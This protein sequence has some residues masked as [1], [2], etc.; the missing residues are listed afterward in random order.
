[1]EREVATASVSAD[2]EGSVEGSV[3]ADT[4]VEV[5]RGVGEDS[6]ANIEPGSAPAGWLDLGA[7]AASLSEGIDVSWHSGKVDWGTVMAGGA[8]FAV[9]KATEGVDAL[10]AQFAVNWQALGEMR[11]VRGAYHF[12]VTEDDPAEQARFFIDTVDLAPG[13]LVPIVDI[14]SIGRGTQPGLAD[15]L[16]IF[17]DL[18]EDHYGVRPTI[19]TSPNFWDRHLG[20]GFGDHPLWIAQYG[21]AIPRLPSGWTAWHLWQWRGDDHVDGVPKGADRS[22]INPDPDLDLTRLLVPPA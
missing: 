15:R 12:Y 16:R 6:L 2:A 10:D 13:D 19:Y 21:V 20:P 3:P 8:T 11:I 1:A 14:E 7:I 4:A 9:V 17:L 22:R 5:E 18:L